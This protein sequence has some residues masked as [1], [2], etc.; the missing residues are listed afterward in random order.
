MISQGKA[1]KSGNGYVLT[2]S[3][4]ARGKLKMGEVTILFQFVTPPPPRPKP[5]LPASMRGGWF[6]GVN[7]FLAAVMAISAVIQVGFVV[8]LESQ[9]WPEQLD[10]A[11]A[12]IPDRFVKIMAEPE[13]E[14]P[15]IP[16]EQQQPEEGE[17]EGESEAQQEQP[18]PQPQPKKQK[19]EEPKKDD[20]P[21]TAEERAKAE[22]ERRKRM[23]EKVR[24]STILHQIG[25]VAGEDGNLANSLSEGAGDTT[26]QAAFEG[27]EGMKA[28]ELG[29]E[30][31]GLRTS[32]SSDAEGSGSAAGIGDLGATS[33]AKE[34]G[35]GV[36]TGTKKEETVKAKV[37]IKGGGQQIGTG[38]LDANRLSSVVRRGAGAI[39]RCFERELKKNPNAGGKLVITVT[40]G[41]AGRATNVMVKDSG[42]G[43]S[44]QSCT[45]RAVKRWRFPRPKGGDVTFTKTF[46]LEGSK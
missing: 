8:W 34:A 12:E 37:D 18:K 41:R 17:G 46:V 23:A 30:K 4:R 21:K 20:K 42:I 1:K 44:M 22:A 38:K 32:G 3:S 15:E 31:S 40:V 9:E 43:G 24:K 27:S 36:K 29:A 16:E 28:G 19:S 26:M 10:A 39:K 11:N 6:K 13:P 2:L 35:K 7:P 14:E 33:G 5:V 45:K 25:A